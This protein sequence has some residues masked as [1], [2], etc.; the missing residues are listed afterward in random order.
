MKFFN[1]KE[2]VLD[3]QLTQYGKHLLSKGE[4]EPTYYAFFDD[5]VLYD[6]KYGGGESE[7]QNETQDRIEKET[8]SL[9]TQYV[10]SGRE[11]AVKENN[12]RILSG[13]AEM[14][15]AALQQTADKHYSM[16]AP[17]GNSDHGEE[18]MRYWALVIQRQY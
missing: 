18:H 15:D 17:L 13:E 3:I 2:D 12:K 7:A 5:D 6:S 16:S 10:F 9:R 11:T 14:G 8:P 4:L 1:K